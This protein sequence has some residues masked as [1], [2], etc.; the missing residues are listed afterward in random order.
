MEMLGR[1]NTAEVIEYGENKVY[2][3]FFE[4]YPREYINQEYNNAQELYALGLN[5]PKPY[6]VVEVGKRTGIVYEMIK[7]KSLY[8]LITDDVEI[9]DKWLEKF[10]KLQNELF[11]KHTK[12]V[13]SYKD[14]LGEM[15]KSK[16]NR[17]QE[18]LGEIDMLPEGDFLLHGDFHPNNILVKEDNT[19][20]V[21]DLMNVCHGPKEYEIA[22][23]Y[24]LLKDID[25]ILAEKYLE[26]RN[27]V[28]KD[29]RA[30][31]NVIELCRKFEKC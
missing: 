6:A 28:K 11:E 14:F 15:I 26:K 23:T 13:V 18:L 27:V 7:G 8:H 22:R 19:F 1:G 10:V 17:D 25:D 31:I 5:V 9:D 21:I 20:V 30:Y 16:P 3:L 29:I 4:G 12:N 24:Y 2:K